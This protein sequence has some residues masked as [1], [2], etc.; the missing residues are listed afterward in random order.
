MTRIGRN[1]LCPCGSGKK[2]K[3]CCLAKDEAA[4]Y[5]A[6][7]MPAG[8]TAN[9]DE[10]D[11][12]FEVYEPDSPQAGVTPWE[13]EDE[14][15]S[16]E[17]VV[18]SEEAYAPYPQPPEDL[19]AISPEASRLVDE[20]WTTAKTFYG[21]TQDA[22]GMLLH[23]TR[24]M[25]QHPALVAHL[26][27]EHEYLFELGAEL[28]RRQEWSR[29]ADLLLRIRK[30]HPEVYVRNFGYFDYDLIIE[31]L[32]CNRSAD[33]PRFFDFFHQYPDSNID[34]AGRVI[35]LLAWT[36][37]QDA[38]FEF[39]KPLAPPPGQPPDALGTCISSYW[40][41]FAQYVPFLDARADP[42]TAARELV[43]AMDSL[44]VRDGPYREPDFVECEL[45]KCLAPPA[46]GDFG[47]CRTRMDIEVFYVGVVWNYC[48]FL[49]AS[50]GFPW[51]KSYF[52]AKALGRY[53]LR[54]AERG[55]PKNPFPFDAQDLEAFICRTCRDFTS[56][57]GVHAV[58]LLEATWHFA[59]YLLACGIADTSD[60]DLAHDICG[61]LFQRCLPTLDS[62][63]PVP[64]LMP[65][66][67]N[68]RI[69]CL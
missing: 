26:E 49:H 36:G 6:P 12:G 31:Q 10:P 24:F 1:E 48:G 53:W 67:P 32:A 66:F 59:D 61:D 23:L 7:V 44:A 2:Y 4:R 55:K 41:G 37:M 21:K 40:L 13:D 47:A 46:T 58:T 29:Y 3:K 62:M 54:R 8:T 16:G 20:W 52:L 35:E 64:R 19:P 15:A 27:L 63:D 38:L 22:D 50:R 57:I 17:Y 30:Q 18:E 14:D 5:A 39:V 11:E 56:I 34:N 51:A 42:A 45:R 33:I 65:D 25:D 69:E 68:M 9:A 28:G 60:R 43:D